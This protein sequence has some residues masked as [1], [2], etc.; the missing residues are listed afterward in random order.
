MEVHPIINHTYRWIPMLLLVLI[1]IVVQV[2]LL[3]GYTGAD[4][5]P[6]K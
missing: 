1:L 4:Y 3:C 6:A 5:L 2:A